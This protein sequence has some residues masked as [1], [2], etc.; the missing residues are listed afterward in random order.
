MKQF[1]KVAVKTKFKRTQKDKRYTRKLVQLYLNIISEIPG[2]QGKKNNISPYSVTKEN[3]CSSG[4][5][6]S[7]A[8]TSRSFL[9]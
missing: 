8:L 1:V 5:M 3:T 7:L 2:S 6:L 4:E 9:T